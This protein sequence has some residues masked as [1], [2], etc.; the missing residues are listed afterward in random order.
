MRWI[1]KCLLVILAINAQCQTAPIPQLQ[2]E[3]NSFVPADSEFV[4][5]VSRINNEVIISITFNDSLIFDYAA[6]ERKAEFNGEFSQCKYIPYAEVKT[7][8][9]HQVKKDIYAYAGAND[10]LYRLKLVTNDGVERIF[11]AINLPAVKK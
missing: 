8:G 5:Q 10:V 1:F 9:R 4:M 2:S 11:P 7:K 3:S 6:I